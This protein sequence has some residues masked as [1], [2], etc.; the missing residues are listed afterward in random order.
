MMRLHEIVGREMVLAVVEPRSASD[1]LFEL[2]H[3]VDGAH[4]DD[5]ADV[6]GIHSG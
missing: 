4:Q 6:A 3:R 2:N 5:V 1:D